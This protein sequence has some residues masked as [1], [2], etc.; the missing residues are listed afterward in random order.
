MPL[1]NGHFLFLSGIIIVIFLPAYQNLFR[2]LRLVHAVLEVSH[3]GRA[4]TGRP[5]CIFFTVKSV[6][7]MTCVLTF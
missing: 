7:P 4:N 2:L 5:A 6:F 3:A 1:K